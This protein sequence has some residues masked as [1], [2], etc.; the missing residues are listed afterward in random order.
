MVESIYPRGSLA[1]FPDRTRELA[2]ELARAATSLLQAYDALPAPANLKTDRAAASAW[3]HA[4][5]K[6]SALRDAL[7][8]Y[9][10]TA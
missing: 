9:L 5:A 2:D 8:A 3:A 4:W 6:Q 7:A 1:G 10:R